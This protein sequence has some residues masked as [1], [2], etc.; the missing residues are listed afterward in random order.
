M[1]KFAKLLFGTRLG[2]WLAEPAPCSRFRA[3]R[4]ALDARRRAP[5]GRRA[6]AGPPLHARVRLSATADALWVEAGMAHQRPPRDPRRA[7]GRAR[8]RLWHYDVVECFLAGARRPLFRARARR[9]RSLPRAR[10]RRAAPAR[11]RLRA[12]TARRGLAQQ[13]A[14]AW[15]ARCACR[16]R[17][18]RRAG[19][20][21]Q[22]VRDRARRVRGPCAG[23]RG[24][25]RLPPPARR[26]RRLRVPGWERRR[27]LVARTA[28][29]RVEH[30]AHLALGVE[31]RRGEPQLRA[32]RGRGCGR[33]ARRGSSGR[34]RGSR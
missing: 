23:G 1:K 15:T 19:R 18:C 6:A 28:R 27:A 31:H 22:R 26:S 2:R 20:T 34:R 11:A 16:A 21:R 30:R 7:A 8:G 29:Q 12:R 25:A 4:H 10:V 13:R 14:S 32:A 24:A 3:R 9:G 5:L 33:A 17:G